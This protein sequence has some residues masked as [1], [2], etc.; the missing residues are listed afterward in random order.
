MEYV[1]KLA[2]LDDGMDE[3]FRK[4]FSQFSFRETTAT[5]VKGILPRPFFLCNIDFKVILFFHWEKY[6]PNMLH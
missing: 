4:A 3:E 6:E 1:P 5:Q 2:E